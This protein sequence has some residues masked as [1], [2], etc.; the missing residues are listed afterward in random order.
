VRK[1]LVQVYEESIGFLPEHL[2]FKVP[3][4]DAFEY[5]DEGLNLERLKQ[6]KLALECYN[7]AIEINSEYPEA[8]FLRGKIYKEVKIASQAIK[9]FTRAI[10]LSPWFSKAY[11][12]RGLLYL[13]LGR[14]RDALNDFKRYTQVASLKE[15][16]MVKLIRKL[17]TDME[18]S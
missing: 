5:L 10:E 4:P 9:D 2:E 14:T 3:P 7:R 11:L 1:E 17:I 18:K 16:P 6:P 8:Y 15:L 12:E 13:N